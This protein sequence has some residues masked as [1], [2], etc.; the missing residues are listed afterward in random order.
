MD[1]IPIFKW[2]KPRILHQYGSFR[3]DAYSGSHAQ[4]GWKKPAGDFSSG[5]GE[6]Q[7]GRDL[8]NSKAE[9]R[10]QIQRLTD[11]EQTGFI[12]SLDY[13]AGGWSVKK[14]QE[15]DIHQSHV[16]IDEGV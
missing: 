6:H 12:D 2:M 8:A 16:C 9:E 4:G 11:S 1:Y 13:G 5:P 14:R 10:E 15:S 3:Q 7:R